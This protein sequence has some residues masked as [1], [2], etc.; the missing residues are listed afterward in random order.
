[1]NLFKDEKGLAR[2][3]AAQPDLYPQLNTV[4][5]S[6]AANKLLDERV[7]EGLADTRK[8][9]EQANAVARESDYFVFQTYDS[10]GDEQ[11]GKGS[12]YSVFQKVNDKMVRRLGIVEVPPPLEVVLNFLRK[13]QVKRV[14]TTNIPL[15]GYF[16]I[17]YESFSGTDNQDVIRQDMVDETHVELFKEQGIELVILG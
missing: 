9:L 2:I 15:D 6:L 3:L 1:M 11:Y 16:G 7:E 4:L 17:Q 12:G 5:N 8:T 10:W 13:N 14:F